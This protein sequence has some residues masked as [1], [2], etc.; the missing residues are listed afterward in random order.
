MFWKNS[1]WAQYGSHKGFEEITSQLV[2][3]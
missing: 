2:P 3:G 1:L